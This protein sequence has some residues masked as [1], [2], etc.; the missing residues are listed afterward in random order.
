M[1][2]IIPLIELLVFIALILLFNR[3]NKF[4]WCLFPQYLGICISTAA[5]LLYSFKLSMYYQT[6][7]SDK[8]I[9]MLLT[10]LNLSVDTVASL[11]HFGIALILLS[12]LLTFYIFTPTMRYKYTLILPIAYYIFVNNPSTNY[13]WFI[14]SATSG[15][16]MQYVFAAAYATANL[17]TVVYMIMPIAALIHNTVHT[18]IM[19]ARRTSAVFALYFLVSDLLVMKVFLQ[20]AFI[21]PK[22]FTMQLNEYFIPKIDAVNIEA[23]PVFLV[24]I[25]GVIV[26]L[27]LFTKPFNYLIFNWRNIIFHRINKFKSN[28]NYN[29]K[30]MFH[31]YKNIF[32]AIDK[33]SQLGINNTDEGQKNIIEI[34]NT[35][36]DIS[37]DSLNEMSQIIASI[38][39]SL[40]LKPMIT[41][42]YECVNSA[43][44]D[45]GISKDSALISCDIGIDNTIYCDRKLLIEAISNILKN[46]SEACENSSD[47]NIN[48]EIFSE[49]SFVVINITDHG[50]G[51][52]RHDL[53]HIFKPFFSTKSGGSNRGLGLAFTKKIINLHNGTIYVKSKR[54]HFTTF[55]IVL[56]IKK[57]NNLFKKGNEY[58]DSDVAI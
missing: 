45:A 44:R 7:N 51:I 58:H 11:Y 42:V 25:L 39:D 17:V 21:N 12:N 20:T 26:A 50:A 55:Q 36:S 52:R 53:W 43:L 2:V 56:P 57:T 41:G 34:F 28:S 19:N 3:N 6:Y 49:L 40:E 18:R 22:T 38:D 29:L 37:K 9:F 16:N 27:L 10:Q 24:I 23:F 54:N 30:M 32:S 4:I 13:K 5:M 31:K 8:N 35:I 15:G 1:Y 33:F 48:I 46:A 47:K 14:L